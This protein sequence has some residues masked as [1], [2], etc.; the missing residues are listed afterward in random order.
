MLNT[1][2]VILSAVA[3]VY[4]SFQLK[5]KKEHYQT[6][7]DSIKKEMY[8]KIRS[9]TLYNVLAIVLILVALFL[10]S[11]ESNL[12]LIVLIGSLFISLQ[13]LLGFSDFEE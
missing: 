5:K 13:N 12:T 7:P 1:I 3:G 2:F 6:Y 9:F 8:K 4:V 11:Q 10:L